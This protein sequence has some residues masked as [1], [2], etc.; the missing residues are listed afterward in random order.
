MEI[1]DLAEAIDLER[2]RYGELRIEV[3]VTSE[4]DELGTATLQNA[5]VLWRG[6]TPYLQ[7]VAVMDKPVRVV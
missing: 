1:L 7:L 3:L 5:E 6:G 2:Q 4:E